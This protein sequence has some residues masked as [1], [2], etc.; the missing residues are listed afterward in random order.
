MS[1]FLLTQPIQ[2]AA[3]SFLL[4]LIFR[5][6]E[7]F[8][9]FDETIE[10]ES[11][12]KFEKEAKQNKNDLINESDDIEKSLN[13]KRETYLKEKKAKMV[14]RE[15]L[16]YCIYLGILF[17][18]S[19]SNKDINSFSYQNNL[20]KLFRVSTQSNGLDQVVRTSDI[21]SW[22][23]NSFINGINARDRNYL[24]DQVSYIIGNPIIRQLRVLKEKCKTLDTLKY[25]F[26]DYDFFNQDKNSYGLKWSLN[27]S[28]LKENEKNSY[29]LDSFSYK[30]SDKIETYPYF[31]KYSS[32]FGGGYVYILK[33]QSLIKTIEDLKTLEILEW[34]DSQTRV[35][36]IEFSLFN[37]NLNLFAYCTIIFE[38][39]PTGNILA[40]SRFEPVVLYEAEN[41]TKY[42]MI[43]F[44]VIFIL[45]I[46]FFMF[47]AIRLIIKTKMNYFKKFWNYIDW[48]IFA[49][50]WALLSIYIYKQFAKED[51]FT[52]IKSKNTNVVKLQ[53]L[54]Y[55]NDILSILFGTT[56]LT[57]SESESESKNQKLSENQQCSLSNKK[58]ARRHINDSTY[59]F[60]PTNRRISKLK[61]K[62]KAFVI[63][64]THFLDEIENYLKD[65]KTYIQNMKET[66]GLGDPLMFFKHNRALFPNLTSKALNL[67]CTAPTSV[68]AESLFSKAGLKQ[69]DLRNR[70]NPHN[71]DKLIF[72]KTNSL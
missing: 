64:D 38:L 2:V 47:K 41:S 14:L 50:S 34:I 15:I 57:E 20:K 13:S 51:L 32:Y 22:I 49:F 72:I 19:Y 39:L 7:S 9:N 44:N 52:K 56:L 63:T 17:I 25:C 36:F 29:L 11:N 55:W 48:I 21:Y 46:S 35:V 30:N 70:L 8:T 69:N 54:S 12:I 60:P 1:S 10:I 37:V 6:A 65:S 4:V 24:N 61:D 23:R 53:S 42:L 3:I 66:K 33:D 16:C 62:K 40:S 43:T 59:T 68:S 45:F 58:L 67:F 27:I 31:G 5:K 18:V 28:E 71:L 26:H